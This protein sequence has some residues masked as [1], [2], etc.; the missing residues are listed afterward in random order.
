MIS[1]F[2]SIL[3]F[4]KNKI[5]AIIATDYYNNFSMTIDYK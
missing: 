4:M 3:K 5:I 1:G 2:N